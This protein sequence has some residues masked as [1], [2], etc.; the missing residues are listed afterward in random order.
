VARKSSRARDRESFKPG[1]EIWNICLTPDT[2]SNGD[3]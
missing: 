1:D 2:F 3:W